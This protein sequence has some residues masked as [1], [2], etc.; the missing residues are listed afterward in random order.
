MAKQEIRLPPDV[1]RA[2]EKII[3]SGESAKVKYDRGVVKV[4]SMDLTL[5][6]AQEI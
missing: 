6:I 4:H 3:S 2:I 1:I 5:E